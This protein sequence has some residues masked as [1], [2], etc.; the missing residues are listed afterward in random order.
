[1]GVYGASSQ[2][3]A[4]AEISFH[5]DNL[6]GRIPI[7]K[8]FSLNNVLDLTDPAI[9][10][11]LGVTLE[12]ITGNSYG[13]TQELGHFARENGFDGIRA[14][15]ARDVNGYNIISFEGF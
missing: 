15:S 9:R 13:I 11:D 3:T 4:L 2:S 5:V 8:E 7:S 14:P 10:S 1:G 12:E 6:D